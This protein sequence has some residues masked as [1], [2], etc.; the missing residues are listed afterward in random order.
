MIKNK[1]GRR[2]EEADAVRLQFPR[3]L[4]STISY[5]WACHFAHFPFTFDPI[6]ALWHINISTSIPIYNG[7]TSHFYQWDIQPTIWRNEAE[8]CCLEFRFTTSVHT[9]TIHS[10]NA[11][12]GK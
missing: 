2:S 11:N 12:S 8:A 10:E 9:H 3:I 1:R 6:L 5:I 4:F 7:V